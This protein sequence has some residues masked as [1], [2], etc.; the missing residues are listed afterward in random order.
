M[1]REEELERDFS[2]GDAGTGHRAG[3][4]TGFGKKSFPVRVVRIWCGFSRE[5]LVLP[6]LE[7]PRDR[8]EPLGRG[9]GVHGGINLFLRSLPTQTRLSFH[10]NSSQTHEKR[11]CFQKGHRRVLARKAPRVPAGQKHPQEPGQSLGTV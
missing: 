8:L 7:M 2:A 1:G 11:E 9:E 10:E 5:F 3:I 6:S 4:E